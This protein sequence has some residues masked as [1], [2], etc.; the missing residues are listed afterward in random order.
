MK[1]NSSLMHW[2]IALRGVFMNSG[3]IVARRGDLEIRCQHIPEVES[4]KDCGSPSE[5]RAVQ[6]IIESHL[7]VRI[8]SGVSTSRAS[9]PPPRPPHEQHQQVRMDPTDPPE[10][11]HH[12]G[13]DWDIHERMD[14][15][16]LV[17]SVR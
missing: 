15:E 1:C 8:D 14:E 6:A 11:H 17:M 10:Q 4:F 3:P 12:D 13:N 7:R 5:A 2:E 16:R 9:P